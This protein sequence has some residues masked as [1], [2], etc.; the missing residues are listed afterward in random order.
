MGLYINS[1]DVKIRLS[2]KVR[3]M[4]N[5]DPDSGAMSLLLLNKLIVEAEGAV[6]LDLSERYN[7]PFTTRDDRGFEE[8]PES[9]TKNYI[10]TLCELKAVLRVLETDFGSGAIDADDYMK[11]LSS[12]YSSM[13]NSLLDRRG[14]DEDH[15]QFRK[16]PLKD[17]KLSY[18]NKEADDGFRGMVMNTSEGSPYASE[19]IND[20]GANWYNLGDIW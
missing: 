1:E 5:P 9:P 4:D 7:V 18:H 2:G 20:P 17:L 6:E 12:R 8:L 3:V 11:R 13:V 10:K 14:K 16:P 19:Q 15:N